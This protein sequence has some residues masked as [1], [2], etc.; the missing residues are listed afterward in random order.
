[1]KV[2][3]S[4][5]NIRIVVRSNQNLCWQLIVSHFVAVILYYVSIRPCVS[6]QEKPV[7]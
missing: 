7:V 1:M 6:M 5:N 4:G 2:T 3:L